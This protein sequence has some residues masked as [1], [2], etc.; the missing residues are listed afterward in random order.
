[1]LSPQITS[2]LYTTANRPSGTLTTTSALQS[3]TLES[4]TNTL[5]HSIYRP[6]CT[7]PLL[8][9]T[10]RSLGRGKL[11]THSFKNL[12]QQHLNIYHSTQKNYLLPPHEPLRSQNPPSSF[13]LS[14]LPAAHKTPTPTPPP[15]STQRIQ[16]LTTLNKDARKEAYKFIGIQTIWC[17]QS[18]QTLSRPT[19]PQHQTLPHK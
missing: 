9:Q 6:T 4:I 2:H 16:D 8:Y 13:I 18:H 5:A 15:N 3:E 11:I 1:M 14:T 12:W 17:K 10:T 7:C 19:P